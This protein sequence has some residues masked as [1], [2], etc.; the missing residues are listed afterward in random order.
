MIKDYSLDKYPKVFILD[1]DG[2]MTTGSFFYTSTGK[3]MKEFGP[4]DSDALK[5]IEC[6]LEIRFVSGDKRGFSISKKRIVDDMGFKLDLV[7]TTKR[8][9]WITERYKPDQV[10]YMGDG[11]FDHLV[12]KE[13]KYSI[14][15]K[16]ADPNAQKFSNFT[17]KRKGGD[18]AVA[19]AVMHLL[20][21]FFE[22][23]DPS[24]SIKL[25]SKKL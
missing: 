8:I 23:F 25:E 15:P 2:V 9:D 13:V 1:V 17:T 16:N 14:A 3:V 5:L 20:E 4:D 22:P 12:M 18:R 11:I 6:F 21:K 7:S 19:E 24:V 10:I